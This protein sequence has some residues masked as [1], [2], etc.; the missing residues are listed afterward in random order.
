VIGGVIVYKDRRHLT[1]T[2]SESLQPIVESVL[3]NELII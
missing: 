2:Y 1:K 3:T